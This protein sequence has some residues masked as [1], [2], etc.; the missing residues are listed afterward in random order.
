MS[1][2]KKPIQEEELDKVSGGFGGPGTHVPQD[3]IRPSG[4]KT[5]P[6]PNPPV[7]GPP[8]KTG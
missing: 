2:E 3:P 8:T 5:N 7:G 6:V 1:D 4:P